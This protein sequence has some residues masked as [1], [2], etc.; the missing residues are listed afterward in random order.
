MKVT[1]SQETFSEALH[2]VSR[3]V[4]AKNTFPVLSGVYLQSRP[5]GLLLRS[6]DLELAIECLA[7]AQ[8]EEPGQVVLP[9]R[10]LTDLIR[11]SPYGD[12][13]LRVD[14]TNH[15]ADVSWAKSHYRI[16][17]F[18]ADQFPVIPEPGAGSDFAVPQPVLRDLLRKTVLAAAH[19][20]TRPYLTGVCLTLSGE[21]LSAVA[22]DSVRIAHATAALGTATDKQIQAIVPSRSLNELTRVLTGDEDDMVGVSVSENQIAFDLGRLRFVSRLLEGQ[23]PDIMRLVPQQYGTVATVDKPG[24]IDAIERASLIT[25]DGAVKLAFDGSLLRI[26]ANTPEVG[27]A[28]EEVNITLQGEPL[29]IGFNARYLID[30]LKVLDGDAFLFEFSG[31]RNPSR[32]RAADKD[33]FLYVVLPLITY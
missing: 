21:R 31:A 4:S 12:I 10:Y 11:R 3:A 26:T 13:R 1:V 25:K 7:E 14:P 28:D 8:I 20:D 2:T 5:E 33:G 16:H 27:Q 32:I 22:T 29:E 30:G 6:T 17:G 23:Y 18:P 24:F 9:A 15:V 19:D